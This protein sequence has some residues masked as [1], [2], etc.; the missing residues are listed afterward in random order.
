MQKTGKIKEM[1]IDEAE[2]FLN[3]KNLYPV[4][5]RGRPTRTGWYVKDVE[6]EG[7]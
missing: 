4:I 7:D 6:D 3:V 1:A 2:N 5:W